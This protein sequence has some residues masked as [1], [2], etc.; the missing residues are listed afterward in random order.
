MSKSINCMSAKDVR[1]AIDKG[2]SIE[3]LLERYDCSQEQF[4]RR[5]AVLYKYDHD[6]IRSNL[7]K[8]ASKKHKKKQKINESLPNLEAEIGKCT[9]EQDGNNDSLEDLIAEEGSISEKIVT[10]EGNLKAIDADASRIDESAMRIRGEIEILTTKLSNFNNKLME[11]LDEKCSLMNRRDNTILKVNKFKTELADIRAK[12]SE[13][14][15]VRL[16]VHLNGEFELPNGE[17]LILDSSTGFTEKLVQLATM[18]ELSEI[19]VL[20][21]RTIAKTLCALDNSDREF[22]LEYDNDELEIACHIVFEMI[23]NAS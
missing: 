21:L 17:D 18:P 12:I 15:K 2:I 4:D 7:I 16:I 10:L 23:K 8:S 5:L 3:E 6:T 13:L 1:Y 20:M 14:T 9:P 19:N 22:A 11:L